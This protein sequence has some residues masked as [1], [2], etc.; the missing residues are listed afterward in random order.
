MAGPASTLPDG[1]IPKGPR[2]PGTTQH[3]IAG[4]E[5]FSHGLLDTIPGAGDHLE[6][7]QG[8]AIHPG[9]LSNAAGCADVFTSPDDEMMGSPAENLIEFTGEALIPPGIEEPSTSNDAMPSTPA[10]EDPEDVQV[11]RRGPEYNSLASRREI[12]GA[13]TGRVTA[14]TALPADASTPTQQATARLPTATVHGSYAAVNTE[15]QEVCDVRELGIGRR[16]AL[17]LQRRRDAYDEVQLSSLLAW[18]LRFR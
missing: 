8:G 9:F 2:R 16:R 10:P 7:V 12:Y 1:P 15:E 3:A 11:L 17:R 13:L 14:D 6:G 5:H 18:R 4:P